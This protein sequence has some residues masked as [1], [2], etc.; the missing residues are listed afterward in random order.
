MTISDAVSTRISMRAY[1]PDPISP[2]QVRQ[3]NK[4]I[5]QY[6]AKAGLHI[7]LICEQPASR[8]SCAGKKKILNA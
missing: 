3:L 6:N 4:S 8:F 7:Q 5:E 1:L 2:E